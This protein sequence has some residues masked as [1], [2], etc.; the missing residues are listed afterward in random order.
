MPSSL[1]LKV[2]KRCYSTVCVFARGRYYLLKV[3]SVQRCK[4]PDRPVPEVVHVLWRGRTWG[5]VLLRVEM[6]VGDE[7]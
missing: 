2:D 3:L 4:C 6:R 5:D 7:G 1:Q